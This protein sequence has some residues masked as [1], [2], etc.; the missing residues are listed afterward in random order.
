MK[1]NEITTVD[2]ARAAIP[3]ARGRGLKALLKVLKKKTNPAK[4]NAPKL[5]QGDGGKGADE[6]DPTGGLL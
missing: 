4:D 3:K 1:L 6:R 2:S 5:S